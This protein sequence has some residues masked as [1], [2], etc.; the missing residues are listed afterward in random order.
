MQCVKKR[1]EEVSEFVERRCQN[2]GRRNVRTDEEETWK[3]T[4]EKCQ[5]WWTRN[6]RTEG[7][8]LDVQDVCKGCGKDKRDVFTEN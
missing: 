2:W 3:I 7:S 5:N 8:E 4:G 1:K 6:F